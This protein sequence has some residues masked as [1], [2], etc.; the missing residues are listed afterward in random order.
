MTCP[1]PAP[2]LASGPPRPQW[3]VLNCQRSCEVYRARQAEGQWDNRVEVGTFK[4]NKDLAVGV[5]GL[6][7]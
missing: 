3:A 1:C 5:M 6:G 4:D 7:A 2:C